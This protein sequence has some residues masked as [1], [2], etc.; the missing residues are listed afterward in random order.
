MIVQELEVGLRL[1]SRF[2]DGVEAPERL[3]PPVDRR[4]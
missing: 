2:V 4:A 1:S 3:P